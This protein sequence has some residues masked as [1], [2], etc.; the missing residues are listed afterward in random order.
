M[1]FAVFNLAVVCLAVAVSAADPN[2]DD[3]T[4]EAE[5]V[6]EMSNA[7]LWLDWASRFPATRIYRLYREAAEVGLDFATFD[8]RQPPLVLHEN[9]AGEDDDDEDEDKDSS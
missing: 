7:E 3:W 8:L 1:S 9:H 5:V 2:D 4:E 6:E